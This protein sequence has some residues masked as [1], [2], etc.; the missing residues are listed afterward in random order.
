MKNLRFFF[1]L[2][3][4]K[5]AWMLAEGKD[6]WIRNKAQFIM[7]S[8]SCSQNINICNDCLNPSSTRRDDEVQVAP[9]RETGCTA[10]KESQVQEMSVFQ[11]WLRARLSTLGHGEKHYFLI[12]DNKPALCS[13][14]WHYRYSAFERCSPLNIPEK[15]IRTK[16]VGTSAQEIHGNTR[17]PERTVLQ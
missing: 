8:N 1:N 11:D 14:G 12:M 5:F 4:N 17:D 10:G 13:G 7:H 15:R 9:A 6:S 2:E 3:V 16:A